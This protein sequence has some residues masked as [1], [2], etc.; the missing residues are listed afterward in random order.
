MEQTKD[1]R[2]NSK[3]YSTHDFKWIGTFHSIFLK[4]LKEEIEKLNKD[5]LVSKKGYT[6]NF[7]ILDPGETQTVIKEIL[8]SQ[9]LNDIYKPNEVKGFIS[10]MKNEGFSPKDFESK[11]TSEYDQAMGKIY[12]EYQKTLEISNSLDFDDLLL[13]PY[14][15]F[16]QN[17]EILEKWVKKFQYIM[18]DEAQDTN[19]IQFE[20]MKMLSGKDGNIT[21]I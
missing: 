3:N 18:V 11:I 20:L 6:K 1:P 5:K 4:I 8:K 12:V 17:P 13:L 14:M 9:N 7:G 2:S 21:L 16:K 19:W 10:K 15:L